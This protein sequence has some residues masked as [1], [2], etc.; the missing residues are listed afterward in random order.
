MYV[1]FDSGFLEGVTTN[2]IRYH[3]NKKGETDAYEKEKHWES[4]SEDSF[5]RQGDSIIDPSSP[6]RAFKSYGDESTKVPSNSR[7][8]HNYDLDPSRFIEAEIDKSSFMQ[9]NGKILDLN[10]VKKDNF[11]L[12]K[13][14]KVLADKIKQGKHL[15]DQ[16][17][18]ESNFK[19]VEKAKMQA[20]HIYA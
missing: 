10:K 7:F 16:E 12:L 5:I 3:R 15:A 1:Y 11:A 17:Q 13:D 18:A 6:S 2:L 4:A 20:H 19:S 14:E 9:K 8:T